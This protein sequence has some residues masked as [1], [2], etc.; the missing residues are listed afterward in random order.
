M[1]HKPYILGQVVARGGMAEVYRGLQIGRDGF[2]RLVA[3]KRILPQCSQNSEYTTMFKDEAHIGQRLQH[4][5]IVKVECF[6][7]IESSACI[8]M[9]FVDGLDLRSVLAAVEQKKNQPGGLKNFTPALCAYIIAEVARGLHHA[10]TCE[11]LV[12]RKPL[13]I[14]HRDISPQN[15]LISW[16]GEVKITDFGIAAADRDFKQTETKVGIVKGKFAYMSPEQISGKKCD[17]RTDIFA[18]CIVFWE[19]LAMKR[20]FN[21]ENE[22]D[23]I[24]MVRGC[25]IT[26]QLS[27]LNP[28]VS[29]ELEKIVMRGLEQDPSKR[30]ESMLA[31][32]KT[33][34][35]FLATTRSSVSGRELSLIL[36]EILPERKEKSKEDTRLLL[37]NIAI[38]DSKAPSH[39]SKQ[40]NIELTLDANADTTGLKINSN[41][42]LHATNAPSSL[43][44]QPNSKYTQ[45][46]NPDLAA[47]SNRNKTQNSNTS[48]HGL[49]GLAVATALFFGGS[50]LF[51]NYQQDAKRS[52]YFIVKST[53]QSVKIK[54][55]GIPQF[56]GQYVGT[57]IK[58]RLENGVNNV[59]IS[60]D[61]YQSEVMLINT[62]Q[63][64]DKKFEKIQLK[65]VATFSPVRIEYHG[66]GA[67]VLVNHGFAKKIMNVKSSFFDVLD[68]TSA[69]TSD[70]SVVRK[71][72]AKSFSCS[73]VPMNTTTARPLLLMIDDVRESC[74]FSIP[75]PS[76]RGD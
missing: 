61:G 62:D 49:I 9:E 17:P 53:H 19:I 48:S 31:L 59:E 56:K 4:P 10:H 67:T 6:D 5:N 70:I 29:Q 34:R 28:G 40:P 72:P 76:K 25:K 71:A 60:R 64:L 3:I 39:K 18:L 26:E 15:I 55:N 44:R 27:K 58:I 47:Q 54:N 68:I 20:L 38:N 36:G 52:L 45:P 33:I 74:S 24:E 14:I 2:R 30:Y 66:S 12:S 23:V 57:P 16:D 1:A 63:M 50:I 11:D 21:S 43:I 73:F 7:T 32:D 13:N 35:R 22:I 69:T 42:S 37:N 65:A 41:R 8:I 75:A 51:K 46:R